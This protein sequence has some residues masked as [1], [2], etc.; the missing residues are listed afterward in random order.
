MKKTIAALSFFTILASP[1]GIPSVE[2]A[3]HIVQPNESL[4]LLSQKYGTTVKDIKSS[5]NLTSDMIIVGQRLTVPD[6]IHI[7]QSGDF[8]WKIA[9]QYGVTVAQ[10]KEWNHLTSDMLYPGQQ[11]SLNATTTMK[12]TP[13]TITGELYRV[14]SGDSLSVIAK[15]VGVTVEQLRLWNR[16]TSDLIFVGQEL[17]ITGPTISKVVDIASAQTGIP[18]KWGGS[19][20]VGFDCSGFVFYAFSQA[21]YDVKRL[22]TESFYATGKEV[23]TPQVGDIIF[24]KNTYRTGLSHM[25]IYLGNRQF[26][27]ASSSAG[28]TVSSIDNTY[29]NPR[30]VGYKRIH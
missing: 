21:G 24:F 26:I 20:P 27:H 29:W 9:N 5:N 10:L 3:E 23:G 16:L 2:A 22:T 13:A 12:N 8:L 18:Y 7:V 15:R 11:L 14:V 4:F 25:G 28:I 17:K 1:I 30:I 6:S 19:T